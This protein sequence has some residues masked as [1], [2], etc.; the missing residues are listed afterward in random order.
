MGPRAGLDALIVRKSNSGPQSRKHFI[1]KM[2][3]NLHFVKGDF[4]R[5]WEV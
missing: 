1:H 4:Q 2:L 5:T 3:F